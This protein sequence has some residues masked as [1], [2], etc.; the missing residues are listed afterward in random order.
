[1]ASKTNVSDYRFAIF[2]N[3]D[4]AKKSLIEMENVMRGYEADLQNLVKANKKD[5]Q[6][7]KD[8]K[9]IYDDH[10]AKMAE[11]RK[12]AG[13]NSLS[14]KELRGVS[15]QLNNEL[16]RAIP[17]TE[18]YIKLN[19][20][21][22]AVNNRMT[23]LKTEAK[24][25]GQVMD[26]Q[27]GLMGQ[28]M[29]KISGWMMAFGAAAA[30]F[31]SLNAI[32]DYIKVGIE[33]S[34]KLRD[35]ESLLLAELSGQADVQK[36]LID[37]AKERARSTTYTRLEIEEQ[38]KFLAIQERTPAQIKKTMLAAMD[39][40]VVMHS[41]LE[42]A[43]K[44]LDGTMEGRLGKG[45]A[46]LDKDF[47][48]LSK[49]QLYNGD[50]IDLVAK[51]YAGLA[52]REMNTFD[53]MLN[54]LG[55]SWNA[56][57]RTIGGWITGSG[58]A[59]SGLIKEAGS[60]LDTF[61]KWIEIPVSQKLQDESTQVNM[62]VSQMMEA[63][64]SATQRNKLYNEL[65]TI[66][67]EVVAG[68]NSEA[69]SYTQLTKNLE[70]YN[71]MMINKIIIQKHQEEIDKANEG[72]A[73]ARDKRIAQEQELRE[74]MLKN[75]NE[76]AGYD[77][78]LAGKMKAIMM[79]ATKSLLEKVEAFNKIGGGAGLIGK[80]NVL[81]M[82]YA[83]EERGLDKTNKLL[84]KKKEIM[85]SL[86]IKEQQEADPLKEDPAIKKEQEKVDFTKKSETELNEYISRAREADATNIDRTNAR[87]AQKEMN[88]REGLSKSYEQYM[89]LMREIADLEKSNFAEKLSQTQ[90]EI[91]VV[92]EKYD[93]EIKKIREYQE[94]NKKELSPKQNKELNEQVGKLEIVRDQQ[95]KQVLL[96]AEADFADK[97]KVIHENLRVARMSI[98]A[99]EV[100][101]INKKY[102]DAQ[103]EI[104]EA[105]EYRYQEELKAAKGNKEKIQH[106]EQEKADA[107]AKIQDDLNALNKARRQETAKARKAGELRFEEDLNNLKLKAEQD[108]AKDK[109]KIQLEINAKYK[110]LLDEN[111][112]DVYKT[113]QIKAQMQ[114]E[115]RQR[116]A[117]AEEEYIDKLAKLYEG[118]ARKVTGELSSL[119]TTWGNYQ[120]GVLQ[121]DE[122]ANNKEKENLKKRLDSG[123]INQKQYDAK[124]AQ[125]DEDL[126]KKKRKAAHDTAVIQKAINLANAI[127]STAVAVVAA[128]TAGP[129]I[130]LALAILTAAFDAIQVALIAATP[131]P[132]AAKGRYNVIG[133]S[134][135]KKYNNVPYEK[136]PATGIY[137][138]PTIIGETGHEIVINPADTREL[139]MNYPEVIQAIR[140][141]HTGQRAAGYYDQV[142][143]T[144]T[145]SG[146][147]GVSSGR[148]K[149]DTE[150][151]EVLKDLR[152][153]TKKGIPAVISYDYDVLERAK[154]TAIR[155]D[156]T[157]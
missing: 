155:N 110:K 111:A 32:K 146:S 27:S 52:E 152:D 119:A 51:K 147:A 83:E 71:A 10:I 56:L 154:I 88:R 96:Q 137:T 72:V 60:L 78:H 18:N 1:M 50:A 105:I 131:I 108:L 135:G 77:A 117:A 35:A 121:R 92:N 86:G 109:E 44:T 94:H 66:A 24:G 59:F 101:D 157:K 95:T 45:L 75:A 22:A 118:Y 6:E 48:N 130:G 150:L 23:Q 144:G 143:S 134:D 116:N 26:Q 141:V 68:L 106:A 124:S 4:Q 140:Y 87:L 120:D 123:I 42:E 65:Q 133:A 20:E 41:S 149:T 47:K 85:D 100:Y 107:I 67:P 49:E 16:A 37:L 126:N 38:E 31:F 2:I 3:N 84:Q 148:S 125:L 99:R 142:I 39:L 7:Y 40:A 9:K 63:N 53:G 70:K 151:L 156:V 5:S 98:T 30:A 15:A 129:G 46:K 103:K 33:A 90:Q 114:E 57:Q 132:E 69:I 74:A 128:S 145:G 138:K 82:Y 153:Q 29:G 14:M 28:F 93:N 25:M 54:K 12:E 115:F 58:G 79:D 34:L 43:V 104:L 8:K 112:G 127:I 102:D 61:R 139:Q 81:Q 97:V 62:L 17:G 64:V 36:A 89:D 55:K 73:S 21:L 76:M 136:D 80:V 13:L 122:A 113:E 19:R 91:K 11:M